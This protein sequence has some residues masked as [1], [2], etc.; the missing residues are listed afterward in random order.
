MYPERLPREAQDMT[1]FDLDDR[2][3]DVE[4]ARADQYALLSLCLGAAPTPGLLT[5]LAGLK[6]DGTTLGDAHAALARAAAATTAEDAG[7]D[8]FDLFVGVGR[9]E[10]LPYGSY[11]LTGFLNERPLAA[12]RA[13][14]AALGVE[15]AEGLHDPEDHIAILSA[16][17]AD[18]AR[19]GWRGSATAPD[20]A[21]FF[22]RHIAPWAGRFFDDLSRARP[23]G[24][25]PAVGRVGAAFMAVEAEAFALTD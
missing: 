12:V 7:R 23:T 21:T 1:A 3:A 6:G 10:L 5:A 19:K 25:Y 20:Q 2:D 18:L 17:M 13:D 14:M 24:F 9:G 4:A 8:F 15:R 11:Y 22:R 16:V